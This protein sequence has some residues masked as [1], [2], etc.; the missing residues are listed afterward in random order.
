MIFNSLDNLVSFVSECRKKGKTIAWTNGCFDIIHPGHIETF[1]Y[2]K[3]HADIVIVG[4]NGDSSPYFK[5]KPGRPINNESFRAQMLDAIRHIDAVCFF[6]GETPYRE[7]AAIKPDLLIKGGD[8]KTQEIV[9][10]D[11]VTANG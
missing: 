10:Y 7:I 9:G 8:Y 1:K 11:V 5:T 3:Q 4:I 6:E 2:A